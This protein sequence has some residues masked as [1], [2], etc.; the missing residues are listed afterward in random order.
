MKNYPI[1]G[2][3][4]IVNP[5][6]LDA[7]IV[8]VSTNQS[9]LGTLVSDIL[10]G[11]EGLVCLVVDLANRKVRGLAAVA[12]T[13][14]AIVDTITSDAN[15]SG[16][17]VVFQ[18]ED[19]TTRNS[20]WNVAGQPSYDITGGSGN[21][22]GQVI[23]PTRPVI[24]TP[25]LLG[26]LEDATLEVG[27]AIQNQLLVAVLDQGTGLVSVVAF[28]TAEHAAAAYAG[29]DFTIGYDQDPTTALSNVRQPLE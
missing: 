22:K 2:A 24:S 9:T 15:V 12:D 6:V 11:A 3:D 19:Q 14:T 25:G 10:A 16:A 4:G 5:A 17:I 21:A 26:L 28:D 27:N 18:K 7:A 8:P 1:S 23:K 13:A 20:L 29:G